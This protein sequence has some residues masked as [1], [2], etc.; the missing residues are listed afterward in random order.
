MAGRIQGIVSPSHGSD[1]SE[2]RYQT[3]DGRPSR[4]RTKIDY[5]SH[6][7]LDRDFVLIISSKDLDSPR[8]FAEL[9]QIGSQATLA[10]QVSLDLKNLH[11]IDAQEYLFVVDRSDSMATASPESRIDIA[12]NTL[13][14][15][16]RMLPVSGT[17]FNVYFFNDHIESLSPR[18]LKYNKENFRKANKYVDGILPEGGTGVPKAIRHALQARDLRIPTTIFLLTDGEVDRDDAIKA[19][20]DAVAQAPISAPLRVFTLGIGDG[21]STATCE[22]IATAGNGVCLYATQTETIIGKCARLFRAGRA[23][24]LRDVSIDWCIPDERLRRQSVASGQTLS[25]ENIAVLSPVIEQTPMPIN[26]VHSGTQTIISAIIQLRD[27]S[28]P[29]TVYLHGTL[30]IGASPFQPVPITVE[31][32]HLDRANKGPHMIHTLAAWRLIKEYEGKQGKLPAT[33]IAGLEDDIRKALIISLGKRYQLVSPYTSFIAIDS[34]QDDRRHFHRQSLLSSRRRSPDV[35]SRHD[36]GKD[37]LSFLETAYNLLLGFFGL[38]KNPP[39]IDSRTVP[40][41]WSTSSS[42]GNDETEDNDDTESDASAESYRT[43]STLSS[44]DS[45]DCSSYSVPSSP[46]LRPQLSPVEE[47]IK[48][49]PSP[50]IESRNLDF[51]QAPQRIQLAKPITGMSS[52]FNK[53]LYL[54]DFDGSYSLKRL[55]YIPGIGSAVDAVVNIR[56]DAKAWATALAIAFMQKEMVDQR[57]FHNDLFAKSREFLN[58]TVDVGPDELLRYATQVLASR[59]SR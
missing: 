54:Q 40:G 38:A 2:T 12:K 44:L 15:L 10:L 52:I 46:D 39:L 57:A 31:T 11:T 42:P 8:C 6:S 28:I 14:L 17:M 41:S 58:A 23:P 37:S 3:S 51:D 13:L 16:L 55:R 19:V 33:M 53:L 30:D 59:E 18:G 5:R 25:S 26:N 56:V 7:F 50:R 47:E 45:C 29:R 20:R 35:M 34:G 27:I 24:I 9:R 43:F 4:R 48:C 1:I 22:G 21:I 32:V 36:Q 49:Q